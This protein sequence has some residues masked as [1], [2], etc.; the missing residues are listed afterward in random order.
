MSTE[1]MV[2][3]G[4]HFRTTLSESVAFVIKTDRFKQQ[5]YLKIISLIT[6]TNKYCPYAAVA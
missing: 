2:Q 3:R 4:L 5:V 6:G 1:R